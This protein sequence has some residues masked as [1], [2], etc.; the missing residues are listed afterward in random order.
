MMMM[1]LHFTGQAPFRRVFINALIRDAEGAKMSKSKGNVMDPLELIDAY[2]A[3]ALRFTLTAMSGQARDI[4][5]STARI[6]G[7]RN[8]GT[9]LWNAAR[10]CE[11]N[12]C[13]PVQ[14]FDP[15]GARDRVN[16]W[17]LGETVATAIKV[18]QA[19]ETCAFDAAA[20]ALYRFVWNTYCDWYLELIKPIFRA[21]DA[22][23]TAETRAMAAW[24]LETILRLLHPVAPFITEE[25]W[26][27]TGRRQGLL[28]ST[29]WPRL[30][31][32]W[33]DPEAGSEIN[34]LIE[35]VSEI[36]Q[37]RGE[38]NVPPAAKPALALIGAAPA[39]RDR[40]ERHRPLILTLARLSSAETAPSAPPGSALF[41]A[42]EATGA[43]AIAEHIDI[44]AERARLAREIAAHAA[45]IDRT[46][47]KLANAAFL[48]KAP[49][50]VVEENRERLAQSESAKARLEGALTRLESVA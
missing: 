14:G 32:T 39:S 10:F 43:L 49:D 1:G 20:A 8:F 47:R 42:G 41:V 34:W 13:A 21:A 24:V 50:E 3:D 15:A 9:K 2:G 18:T 26:A 7:Y 16:R 30:S 35:L 23:T 40:L 33:I 4:R 29:D 44:A 25:L 22:A 28:I 45:D 37:L 17:I 5:L 46:A 48:A 19:L 6:E 36:R 11:I 38:M 31:E 12:D 27:K